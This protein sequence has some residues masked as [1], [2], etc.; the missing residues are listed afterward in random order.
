MLKNY[1]IVLFLLSIILINQN[2]AGATETKNNN[3]A[4]FKTEE[5]YKLAEAS[6]LEDKTGL[7]K[8]S[9]FIP[10]L[11]Q[12]Q[13]GDNERGLNFTFLE[14]GLFAS[15]IALNLVFDLVEGMDKNN[16]SKDTAN[17]NFARLIP[18]ILFFSG[19]IATHIWNIYDAYFM[20]QEIKQKQQSNISLNSKE[21]LLSLKD[22]FAI[23]NGNISFKVLK[24]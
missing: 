6:K 9:F 13:M 15:G 20:S 14:G 2:S 22:S 7:W 5:S 16:S 24:F 8:S 1:F 4:F 3:L 12:M 21:K 11:G 19:G 10:G 23:S 17:T 18:H